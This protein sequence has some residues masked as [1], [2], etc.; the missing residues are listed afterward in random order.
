MYVYQQISGDADIIARIGDLDGAGAYAK[1]GVMIRRSL[2]ASAAHA[3]AHVTLGAAFG[4]CA[5]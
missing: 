5:A 4:W 1:A 3:F 2:D